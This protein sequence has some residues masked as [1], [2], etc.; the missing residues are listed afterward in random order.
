MERCVAIEWMHP[1]RLLVFFGWAKG[2][3]SLLFFI[4]IRY[5]SD[6]YPKAEAYRACNWCLREE[7]AK[8]LHYKEENT[9]I[10]NHNSNNNNNSTSSTSNTITT[11]NTNGLKLHRGSFASHLNKPIKKQRLLLNR[12]ASDVTER[13][14]TPEEVSPSSLGKGRQAFRGKVRRYKLLEEVSS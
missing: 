14:R 5:C 8:H 11:S 6:L 3:I 4:Y 9:T 12:S 10:E 13:L 2:T 1:T 7:G